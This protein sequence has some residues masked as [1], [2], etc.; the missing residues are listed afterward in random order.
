MYTQLLFA[1]DRV[2][3]LAPQHPEWKT[4]QPFALLLKGDVKGA[5]A[6]G[7]PAIFK[8]VA[9]THSGMT[10]AEFAEIVC[11]WISAAKHPVT[12]RLY[13]EMVY[14]PHAGA[15]S[16]KRKVG[17]AELLSRAKL[18]L[19]QCHGLERNDIS[20]TLLRRMV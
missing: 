15:S 20:F 16:D 18:Q 5:L 13:P 19:Q 10:N 12:G 8:I 11:A 1:L 14:Q 4:K 3:V 9:A 2:K 6:G 7:E 17:G